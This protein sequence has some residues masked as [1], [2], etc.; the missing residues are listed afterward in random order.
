MNFGW[1]GIPLVMFVIGIVLSYYQ[2]LFLSVNSGAFLFG[3]GIAL[4]P[5]VLAIEGQLAQYLSGM[6]QEI[7]FCAVLFSP[8][9]RRHCRCSRPIPE[10][11]GDFRAPLHA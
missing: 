4:V 11:L 3:I 10:S 6:V 5:Q 8:I 1:I 7:I 2:Q 9:L